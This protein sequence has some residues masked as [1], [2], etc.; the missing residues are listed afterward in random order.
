M[1]IV[2]RKRDTLS[3]GV[4]ATLLVD[5]VEGQKETKEFSISTNLIRFGP[6]QVDRR[7]GE[8]RKHN[9]RIRLSGQPFEVLSL[10]LERPGE[11]VTREEIQQRL[12]TEN[13][14]VDF[15]RS[16]NSAIKLRGALNDDPQGPRYIEPAQERLPLH[17]HHRTCQRNGACSAQGAQRTYP[18]LLIVG[19]AEWANGIC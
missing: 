9:Q 12:W 14:F 16:L 11:V 17:W 6:Y 8:V 5:P 10:L 3:G 1:T 15:E 7:A 2:S 13:I 19:S 18:L 4:G